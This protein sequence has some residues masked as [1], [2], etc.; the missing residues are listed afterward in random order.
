MI[1]SA[2]LWIIY[3]AVYVLTSPLRLLSDVTTN[4]NFYSS[5]I[6]LSE[7]LAN[8]NLIIPLSTV[9]NVLLAILA[10]E[11]GIATYKIIMWVL[12]RIPGQ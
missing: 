10:I 8:L 9:I 3:S 11:V 12:H 1:T 2:I 6:S 7:Y 5:I 4:S